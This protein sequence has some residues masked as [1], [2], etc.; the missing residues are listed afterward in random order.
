ML[1]TGLKVGGAALIGG[2]AYQAYNDWK[3]G[4][5]PKAAA[6]EALPAPDGTAFL[7]ADE[8][9][10]QA[11]SVKLV[12]AMVAAAKADG[13]VTPDER[14]RIDEALGR[15][16][17]E[18]DAAQL[19]ARRTGRSAGRAPDRGPGEDRGRG[20]GDLRGLASGGGRN[21]R[22]RKRATSPCWPRR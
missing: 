5:D 22:W 8:T 4:K 16:G 7:P 18:A 10:A 13:H 1:G 11:L 9:A 6:P 17:L 12:Q 2:L 21:S 3:N 20:S 15:V 14:A 19:F